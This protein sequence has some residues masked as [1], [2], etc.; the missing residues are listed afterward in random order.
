[1]TTFV[2]TIRSTA[3]A[4]SVVVAIV[5][6]TAVLAPLIYTAARIVA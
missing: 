5:L 4:L 2:A 3:K 6:V 1:M